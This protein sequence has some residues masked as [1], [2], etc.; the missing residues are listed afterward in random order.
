M[1]EVCEVSPYLLTTRLMRLFGTEVSE[2]IFVEGFELMDDIHWRFVVEKFKRL[3]KLMLARCTLWR[4][5]PLGTAIQN[6]GTQLDTQRISDCVGDEADF[7][8]V[9]K[10]FPSPAN[11]FIDCLEN[12]PRFPRVE[13]F[14]K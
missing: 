5:Q 1:E 3:K 7:K 11:L 14:Q 13:Q 4:L 12:D 8:N 6:A 2:L 9:F 10:N